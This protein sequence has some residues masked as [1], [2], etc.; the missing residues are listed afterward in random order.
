MQNFPPRP[1]ILPP[2]LPLGP[3]Q[4][5]PTPVSPPAERRRPEIGVVP[6]VEDEA[7]GLLVPGQPKPG[8]GPPP[9]SLDEVLV[10][11]DTLFPLLI[12]VQQDRVLANGEVLAAIGAY[13]LKL[14]SDGISNQID[15][16]DYNRASVALEQ[17]F[18]TGG[19]KLFA[20][21]RWGSGN[22]PTWYGNRQ[23]YG[24]GEF[25]SGAKIPLLRDRNIDKYRADLRKSTIQRA[26]AEPD[27]LKARIE[28]LRAARQA[29]WDWLA[30]GQTYAISLALLRIAEERDAAL[31]RRIE[32]GVLEGIERTDNQRVIVQRRAK[33]IASE[34]KFQQASI[35]LSLFLRG[36]DGLPRLPDANRLPTDFPNAEPTEQLRLPNDVEI[37][38]AR[39]PEL[40]KIRLQRE[41]ANVDLAQAQNDF[42]PSLDVAVLGA[43]DIGDP[44]PKRDKG[45]FQLEA[46]LYLDVPLQRRQARG[47][48]E[49]TQAALTQ[50]N[51]E[52][53][54]LRDKVVTDVQDAV[55][56]ME[57]A[58]RQI[59][60][61]R[62]NERLA[63]LMEQ[64]ERKRLLLGDSNILFVNLRETATFDAA[65]LEVEALAEYFRAV[66]DYRAALAL[67]ADIGPDPAGPSAPPVGPQPLPPH[68]GRKL[69]RYLP[70]SDGQPL[71][72]P[73][74]P[75]P[76]P[77]I[78][79]GRAEK[80]EP[81]PQEDK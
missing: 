25:F 8:S 28:F 35:K 50:I 58:F 49:S 70:T 5:Q 18:A 66:A 21:H 65:L 64:A 78:A 3:G 34:R 13:D 69:D 67:D 57:A 1:P 33:L 63:F 23:T 37:A 79:P 17:Q 20:G 62:E 80:S 12:A 48:I 61:A 81:R 29:Y 6:Y 40:T 11:V 77:G 51:L 9:L 41:K 4:S 38:I 22:F 30:A 75:A 31:V 56:A 36:E 42:L 72:Q 32:E 39:R 43:Q 71:Y 45:Q 10:S 73:P 44:T 74:A 14:R 2:E 59:G 55:S 47:R 68:V 16:Y 54:Y 15:F 24:G 52:E 27:I 19:V 60:E 53:R 7:P 46:G 76:A 26:A